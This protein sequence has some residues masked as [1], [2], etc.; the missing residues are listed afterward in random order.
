MLK[1]KKY[2]KIAKDISKI[3]EQVYQYKHVILIYKKTEYIIF[4]TEHILSDLICILM[5]DIIKHR[6]IR[7][8]L[9]KYSFELDNTRICKKYI[10]CCYKD[11]LYLA[12]TLFNC[13][14]K[15]LYE[16]NTWKK[17]LKYNNINTLGQCLDL[18]Y[19]YACDLDYSCDTILPSYHVY[20]SIT[21]KSYNEKISIYDM[22]KQN[23]C[24]YLYEN[25][26]YQADRTYKHYDIHYKVLI[27][28]RYDI[29]ELDKSVYDMFENY[30]LVRIAK[31]ISEH[32]KV[33]F[34]CVKLMYDK[35][36]L[37]NDAEEKY[38]KRCINDYSSGPDINMARRYNISHY[39]QY[40]NK[41]Q[42]DDDTYICLSI[43]LRILC[44]L[45]NYTNEA[46]CTVRCYY[47]MAIRNM[48]KKHHIY[49]VHDY[50]LDYLKYLEDD[51]IYT[52]VVN[53]QFISD[54]SDIMWNNN[55]YFGVKN[56]L[57]HVLDKN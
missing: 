40:I 11:G 19:I 30:D 50:G 46:T 57:D 12:K 16:Y 24:L 3:V 39:H 13:L 54:Y 56:F 45:C 29:V 52:S 51:I 53:T 6:H 44:G 26:L 55:Y 43:P 10:E 28:C 25:I 48:I 20:K 38:L 17:C 22:L 4:L 31:Y 32:G 2:N 34:T 5:P 35:K 42:Y 9:S 36:E 14:D 8:Y 37:S 15:S 7:Y 18:L 27:R 41:K 23:G 1:Y 47:S 33:D 49:T 21:A